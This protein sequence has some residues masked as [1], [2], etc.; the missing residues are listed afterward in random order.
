MKTVNGQVTKKKPNQ[1]TTMLSTSANVIPYTYTSV[2]TH[3]NWMSVDNRFRL[4]HNSNNLK[5]K[6]KKNPQ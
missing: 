1:K 5:I 6:M 2:H 4:L 3:G